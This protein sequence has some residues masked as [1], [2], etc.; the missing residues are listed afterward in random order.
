MNRAQPRHSVTMQ[1]NRAMTGPT[2]IDRNHTMRTAKATFMA[3]AGTTAMLAASPAFAHAKLVSSNPAANATVQTAPRTITLVFS[4]RVVPAFSKI[5]LSMP[6]HEMN[7]P[8]RSAVSQD[9]KRI[10]G[11]LQTPLHPGSYAIQ[12]TAAGPDGHK[13][14]G[15]INFRVD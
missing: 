8:V 1:F 15:R 5:E 4:E 13:M 7:V 9:G 10:I 2:N 6:E 11:T 12:W 3:I 14:E